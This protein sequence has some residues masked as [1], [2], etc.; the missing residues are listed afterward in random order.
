MVAPVASSYPFGA[1]GSIYAGRVRSGFVGGARLAAT[2]AGGTMAAIQSAFAAGATLRPGVAGGA[3]TGLVPPA[4]FTFIDSLS[5]GQAAEYSLPSLTTSVSGLGTPF[6]P[7]PEAAEGPFDW[8]NTLAYDPVTKSI[9]TAGGRDKA[10]ANATKMMIFD[11]VADL[12]YSIKNPYGVGT[13][14]IYQAQCVIPEHRLHLFRGFQT[15]Q[16]FLWN[17]DSKT[18]IGDLPAP[19]AYEPRAFMGENPAWAWFPNWG[20]YGSVV[21]VGRDVDNNGVIV[22][23]YRA[24][25]PS[26]DFRTGTWQTPVR[27]AGPVASTWSGD[28]PAGC[29]VPLASAGIFGHSEVAAPRQLLIVPSGGATPYWTASNCPAGVSVIPSHGLITPHPSRA[30]AIIISRSNLDLVTYEFGPDTY[31]DR[32]TAPAIFGTVNQ[33]ITTIAEADGLVSLH[34]TAGGAVADQIWAWRVGSTLG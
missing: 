11:A 6:G 2:Q 20:P 9:Y 26:T 17:I 15:G 34:G 25:A 19:P 22:H 5:A 33:G 3:L 12:A 8:V 4:L 28:H 18:Y 32:G 10:V 30:A 16:V 27:V 7:S 31:V 24:P 29:Y 13:G 23:A 21:V 14:H 1:G